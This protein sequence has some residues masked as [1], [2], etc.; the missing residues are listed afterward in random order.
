[1]LCANKKGIITII[2]TIIMTKRMS[3]D[4][5]NVI[6]NGDEFHCKQKILKRTTL[7]MDISAYTDYSTIRRAS[8]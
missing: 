7:N 3:D 1:M 2:I 5:T 8:Q 6:L 4:T